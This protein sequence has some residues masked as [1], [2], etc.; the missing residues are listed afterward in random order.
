MLDSTNAVRERGD[1]WLDDKE[2]KRWETFFI[3]IGVKMTINIFCG[4]CHCHKGNP[5]CINCNSW[6]R[7]V[8]FV[9]NINEEFVRGLWHEA[10]DPFRY[11]IWLDNKVYRIESYGEDENGIFIEL[12]NS[13]QSFK[14]YP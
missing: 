6:T 7:S 5:F 2:V 1:S 9:H 13:E 3:Q 14:Y 11:R 10:G 4:K 8:E 12:Y